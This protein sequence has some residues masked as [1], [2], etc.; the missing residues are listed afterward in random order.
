MKLRRQF[1]KTI[2]IHVLNVIFNTNYFFKLNNFCNETKDGIY[3]RNGDLAHTLKNEGQL[4]WWI[5]PQYWQNI[6]RRRAQIFRN[7]RLSHQNKNLLDLMESF[8][9][10]VMINKEI[11]SKMEEH[12]EGA[13][14]QHTHTKQYYPDIVSRGLSNTTCNDVLD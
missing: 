7:C 12:V 5:I 2:L 13:R 6:H 3:A 1:S 9:L 11:V 10:Y 14:L 8:G 4:C